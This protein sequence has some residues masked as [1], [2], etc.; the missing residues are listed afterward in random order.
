MTCIQ[1]KLISWRKI[2]EDAYEEHRCCLKEGFQRTV[3]RTALNAPVDVD[4]VA[5]TRFFSELT[6]DRSEFLTFMASI[7]R[8]EIV[9]IMTPPFE[10]RGIVF[11]EHLLTL[12]KS[13]TV[14]TNVRGLD[15]EK[16]KSCLLVWSAAVLH[17]I[18]EFFIPNRV[19]PLEPDLLDDVLI[20]FANIDHMQAMWAHSDTAIRLASRSIC[21]LLA[22]R[23]VR[24]RRDQFDRSELDWLNKV[25]GESSDAISNSFGNLPALD[26]MILQSFVYGVFS[27]QAAD[28]PSEHRSTTCFAETLAILTNAG[29]PTAFD[30]T[31]F[32][33]GLL[34]LIRWTDTDGQGGNLVANKLRSMFSNFLPDL[35]Q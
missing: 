27:H 29:I 11:R 21:A 3:I 12:I 10:S 33:A 30:E 8:H 17:I 25:T 31:A 28:F 22:R 34:E 23:L 4:R 14:G 7:P 1:T 15:E 16:R 19:P 24:M 18:K 2:Y 26:H 13:C 6:L 5:L 20:N 9:R 35:S 32:R